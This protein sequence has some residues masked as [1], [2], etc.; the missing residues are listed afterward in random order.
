MSSIFENA[1]LWLNAV[2]SAND[3]FQGLD[4]GIEL[5]GWV[6]LSIVD[7]NCE[8]L[9]DLRLSFVSRGNRVC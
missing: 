1:H 2:Y 9:L 5:G 7:E 4:S 6:E 3:P 8:R